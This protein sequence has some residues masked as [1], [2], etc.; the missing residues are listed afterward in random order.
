MGNITIQG[1]LTGGVPGGEVGGGNNLTTTGAIPYVTS[2]GVLGQDAKVNWL[3]ATSTFSVGGNATSGDITSFLAKSA[4]TNL[5]AS[6]GA[7]GFRDESTYNPGSG[8]GG[9]AS[10][11]AIPVYTSSGSQN[12]INTF[13]SR[14]NYAGSGTIDQIAG[15]T[16]QPTMSGVGAATIT[17]GL[18]VADALGTGPITT[19]YGLLVQPLTRGAG[20]YG[21]YVQGANPSYFGGNVQSGGTVQGTGMRISTG[22]TTYGGI[23]SNDA[24]GNFLANPN[25]TIVNGVL[26]MANGATSKVLASATALELES[27]SGAVIFKPSATERARFA[28]TTGNLL[29]GGTTD[30]NYRLDVQSKGTTGAFRVWDQTATTGT[31]L[32]VIQA[33]QGQSGNL[34]SVRNYAG[35]ELAGISLN[36]Y[37]NVPG[38]YWGSGTGKADLNYY[39]PG[40]TMASDWAYKFSSNTSASGSPDLGLARN[41][42]G[43]LEINNG[44]AGTLRDL[45]LRR[46]R[47][48]GVAVTNLPAAAA[49]NAGTIQYVTDALGPA[50]GVAVVGGGAVPVMVW[51][52]GTAW[53]IFAS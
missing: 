50:V 52:N 26:T 4:Q 20:N 53:K 51:S 34:L 25:L 12:H 3:T 27:T 41:A 37:L 44:T 39:S 18:V 29:I 15:H 48:E 19:Q 2:S 30:G 31:T 24:S 17:A 36:G 7:H 32:A 5:L 13:Q 23:I 42:A 47:Y 38:Q 21:V 40:M 43:V 11:D 9:Y 16:F 28:A 10:Y 46:L 14:P 8:S 49:G 1:D 45:Y 6:G 22:F 35:T 33:G